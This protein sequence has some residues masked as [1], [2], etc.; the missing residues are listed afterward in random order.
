MAVFAASP[1][2]IM[3]RLHNSGAGAF[4]AHPTVVDSMILA[5]EAA[6]ITTPKKMIPMPDPDPFCKF[7]KRGSGAGTGIVFG[8]LIKLVSGPEQPGVRSVKFLYSLN[9][10]FVLPNIVACFSVHRHLF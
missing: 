1:S 6:S 2:R 10:W 4:G 9:S 8:F 3:D 5:G 7:C